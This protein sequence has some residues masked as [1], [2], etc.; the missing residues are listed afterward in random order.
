MASRQISQVLLGPEAPAEGFK[1]FSREALARALRALAGRV[2][3]RRGAPSCFPVLSRTPDA[4]WGSFEGLWGSILA[5][6]VPP[7][8]PLGP[9]KPPE[10]PQERPETHQERPKSAPRA[11]KSAPRAPSSPKRL[12]ARCL[13]DLGAPSGSILGAREPQKTAKSTVL[14]SKIKVDAVLRAGPEKD[15]KMSQFWPPARP[16]TRPPFYHAGPI[17]P[18]TPR[19]FIA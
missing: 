19:L 7:G 17:S 12:G 13:I 15:P 14:S 8:S 6:V 3:L 9:K 16:K 11:P 2:P 5:P 18:Q 4:S 1:L 10:A